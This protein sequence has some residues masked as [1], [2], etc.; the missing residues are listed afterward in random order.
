MLE[1]RTAHNI[2]QTA[3]FL[4]AHIQK[5]GQ[6]DNVMLLLRKQDF[7]AK[8]LI[9]YKHVIAGHFKAVVIALVLIQRVK[10]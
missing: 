3:Y 2:Q 10:L 1:N 5:I 9:F 4:V 7:L 8:Q 6:N